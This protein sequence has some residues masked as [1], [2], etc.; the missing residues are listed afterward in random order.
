M[1]KLLL[2]VV[3]MCCSVAARAD[4][5][6]VATY[7]TSQPPA[8]VFEQTAQL[9]A[10]KEWYFGTRW[11][12]RSINR[13]QGTIQ[14]A[15]VS[16]GVQCGDIY[17]SMAAEGTG[18]SIQAV[19]TLYSGAMLHPANYA[20]RFGKGLKKLFPDLT[21]E[22]KRDVIP[23]NFAF[24]VAR[25]SIPLDA[26]SAPVLQP[27][28][29]PTVNQGPT[30]IQVSIPLDAVTAP[31]APHMQ[32]SVG[33]QGATPISPVQINSIDNSLQNIATSLSRQ[34]TGVTPLTATSVIPMQNYAPAQQ[35]QMGEAT[36]QLGNSLM[37]MGAE[38]GARAAMEQ[39]QIDKDTTRN[40]AT[41]FLSSVNQLMN[42]YLATSGSEAAGQYETTAQAL[43][44]ARDDAYKTLTN[45]IQRNMFNRITNEHMIALGKQMG[46][47]LRQQDFV[48]RKTVEEQY[49]ENLHRALDSWYANSKDWS[50]IPPETW[51]KLSERDKGRL[52]DGIDPETINI[53]VPH[54]DH[55]PQP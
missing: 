5:W 55:S 10:S 25:V 39:Q 17:I 9:I 41:Q 51:N 53:R 14:A 48:N 24:G 50:T 33:S 35:Q 8:Q 22:V 4:K 30:V 23:E 37:M 31:A 6:A 54:P 28:Q 13:A 1:K 43:N 36:Q 26:A 20:A 52:K 12:I 42:R 3:F 44:K 18:T 32:N 38:M 7:H 15:T 49:S 2:A 45:P 40:A 46:D 11:H 27:M 47:H 19:M 21:F 29:N 34:T 16:W